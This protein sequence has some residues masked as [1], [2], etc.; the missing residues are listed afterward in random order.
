MKITNPNANLINQAYQLPASRNNQ[1]QIPPGKEKTDIQTIGDSVSLSTGTQDL[2]K[3]FT[4]A[5]TEPEGR[6]NRVTELKNKVT[7]G[8]YTVNAEK[9]AERMAG[10]FLDEIG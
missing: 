2:Q 6:N 10:Y 1:N 7:Q 4:A 9:V 8:Q 3:I 5:E